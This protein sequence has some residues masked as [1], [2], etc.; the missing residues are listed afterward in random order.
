MLPTLKKKPKL[1]K[2]RE[3]GSDP[4]YTPTGTPIL[5]LGNFNAKIKRSNEKVP[6]KTKI[7]KDLHV[8]E[9]YA[10]S[11]DRKNKNEIWGRPSSSNSLLEL[12]KT[13]KEF[14]EKLDQMQDS[15]IEL[16]TTKDDLEQMRNDFNKLKDEKE[17]LET[18]IKELR[19]NHDATR[20]E[21]DKLVQRVM[22]AENAYSELKRSSVVFINNFEPTEDKL[23]SLDSRE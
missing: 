10:E 20:E 12:R 4:D 18:E 23:P 6:L 16:E 9:L 5:Q 3:C 13:V 15:A 21:V 7:Q 1:I 14:S 22:V 8:I 19:K 11:E 17:K 2:A